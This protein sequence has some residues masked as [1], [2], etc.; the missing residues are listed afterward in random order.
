TPSGKAK[1]MSVVPFV[2]VAMRPCRVSRT[3]SPRGSPNL[4]KALERC[5]IPDAS[6]KFLSIGILRRRG[7]FQRHFTPQNGSAINVRSQE[8]SQKPGQ[9]IKQMSERLSGAQFKNQ[10][11]EGK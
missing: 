10:L 9:E 8:I 4:A 7:K 2:D 6:N 3:A 5:I 11:R 1:K